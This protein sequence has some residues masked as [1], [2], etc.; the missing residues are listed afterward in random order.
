TI[1]PL[2][3]IHEMENGQRQASERKSPAA[4]SRRKVKARAFR[5]KVGKGTF[6]CR[7]MR[8][9]PQQGMRQKQAGSK[10]REKGTSECLAKCQAKDDRKNDRLP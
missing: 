8:S 1:H 10:S 6:V 3:W 9:I 2:S 7:S 5:P 4:E